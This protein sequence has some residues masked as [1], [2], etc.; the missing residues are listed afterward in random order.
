MEFSNFTTVI[1]GQSPTGADEKDISE[2]IDIIE[3]NDVHLVTISAH[4]GVIVW[5][6]CHHI[7]PFHLK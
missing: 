3:N 2:L 5:G 4:S 7:V 6:S 1:W